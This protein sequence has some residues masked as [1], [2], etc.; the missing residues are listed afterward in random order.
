M[1]VYLL[2]YENYVL[3]DR[4]EEE[5]LNSPE[6]ITGDLEE[7]DNRQIDDY[8]VLDVIDVIDGAFI[9]C[10]QFLW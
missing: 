5:F 2:V 7:I 8:E 9:K 1:I 3:D 4:E 6:A 10:K